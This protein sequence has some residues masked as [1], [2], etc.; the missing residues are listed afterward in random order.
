MAVDAL[1]EML[2][3]APPKQVVAVGVPTFW[4]VAAL[5]L[6]VVAV[7]EGGFIGWKLLGGAGEPALRLATCASIRSPRARR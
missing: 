5:A 3:A 2:K 1:R 6:A 7:A 4:R